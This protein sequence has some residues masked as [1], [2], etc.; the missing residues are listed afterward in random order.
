MLWRDEVEGGIITRYQILTGNPDEAASPAQTARME[1]SRWRCPGHHGSEQ[2]GFW[3][4][5]VSWR[6]NAFRTKI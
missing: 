5:V 1:H 2:S 4:R 6:P 3:R